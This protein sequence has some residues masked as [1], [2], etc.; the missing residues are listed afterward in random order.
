MTKWDTI[1]SD[2]LPVVPRSWDLEDDLEFDD[3]ENF[4]D[5]K[6]EKLLNAIGWED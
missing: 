4:D 6:I 1:Q 3:E 5:D 2:I